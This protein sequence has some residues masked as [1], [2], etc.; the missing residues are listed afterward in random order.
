MTNKK[1]IGTIAVEE[2]EL[3]NI[4]REAVRK[5]LTSV[6]EGK[7]GKDKDAKDAHDNRY[8]HD[9]VGKVRAN[10]DDK[11]DFRK[12]MEDAKKKLKEAAQAVLEA[13]GPG[14]SKPHSQKEATM[15]NISNPQGDD[16]GDYEGDTEDDALNA[17]AKDAGYRD[18][19]TL[20]R[21]IPG[22]LVT[23][24]LFEI[25]SRQIKQK[26]LRM[27]GMNMPPM[28]AV[29]KME[30]GK[31]TIANTDATKELHLFMVNDEP[32]WMGN[33]AK[34]IRKNLALKM[35]KGK[36]DS[37]LAPKLWMYLVDA[38]A[39]SYIQQHGSPG[40]RIDSLFNK[41][42]RLALSQ[43][44]AKGFE[45]DVRSGELDLDDMIAAI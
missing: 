8:T 22:S 29:P 26:N 3:R 30:S 1:T 27:E 7:S 32:I 45:A 24:R 5:K 28:G 10:K 42:T 20:Q 6:S 35:K 12:E 40:D 31:P 21:D 38:A 4:I 17:M 44:L 14:S 13:M 19:D 25:I 33:Q 9:K 36:Y 15:W 34:S 11:K 43:E 23:K 39:K 18:Y 16:L 2:E 37:A 41:A